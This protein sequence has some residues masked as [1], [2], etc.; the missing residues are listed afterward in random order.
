MTE[1]ENES[2]YAADNLDTDVCECGHLRGS[3][4]DGLWC[5]VYCPCYGFVEAELA[6]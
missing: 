6:L 4:E 2:W 1:D 5:C 3:H